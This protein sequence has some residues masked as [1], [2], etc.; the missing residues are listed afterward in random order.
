MISMYSHN[1]LQVELI[2][3]FSFRIFVKISCENMQ[4]LG[5]F[6]EKPSNIDFP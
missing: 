2:A 4:Q 5:N 3:K 1:L 6:R